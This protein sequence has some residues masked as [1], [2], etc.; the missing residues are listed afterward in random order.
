M[1]AA[2]GQQRQQDLNP[3]ISSLF[4]PP[5]PA[6]LSSPPF[7]V[8]NNMKA[9]SCIHRKRRITGVVTVVVVVVL[10]LLPLTTSFVSVAFTSSSF[11]RTNDVR[12]SSFSS[13]DKI[14]HPLLRRRLSL[15]AERSN[16]DM[17][18]DW[19]LDNSFEQFLN[20]CSIQSLIFLINSLK[21]RHTALW[22][23]DFTQPIIHSKTKADSS[24]EDQTLSNMAAALK[25]AMQ[26]TQM[27]RPIKLLTYHGLGAINTTR[28]PRGT[29]TLSSY[30]NN[31]SK[32]ISSSRRDPTCRATR[33]TLCRHRCAVV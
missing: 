28:F 29:C 27:V 2:S 23:E 4:S 15:S 18:G 1:A 8:K 12:S 14:R 3:C 25:D 22:L 13:A 32:N 26:E 10:I 20:Q 31:P 16:I 30:C 24:K 33:W 11:R 5:V 21:D 9:I 17:S 6:V 19:Q 7:L